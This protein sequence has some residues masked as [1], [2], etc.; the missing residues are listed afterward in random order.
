M[1][2]ISFLLN[3]VFIREMC[4]VREILISLMKSRFR[5]MMSRPF[6]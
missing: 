1:D 2:F 4:E 3:P 5:D 6:V